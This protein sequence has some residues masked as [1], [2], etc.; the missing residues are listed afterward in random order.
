VAG[1]PLRV[2]IVAPPFYEIPPAGYGGTEA[3]CGSLV[4]GL[5]ARGHEVTLVAAG[6]DHTRARF[7]RTLPEAPGEGHEDE[8]N[9]ELLHAARA[10]SALD[11]CELD[12]V[13]DH[14]RTGPLTAAGRTIPTVATVHSAVAG[15]D[16]QVELWE[17]LGRHAPLI[18]L[19]DA[20]R[21][22]APHLNWHGR[23]YN[24]IPVERYPFREDKEDYVLFLGRMSPRKGVVPAIE[25]A[26]AA[27]RRIVIAGSWSVPAEQSYFEREVRAR[28][29]PDVEWAQ[30]V[31]GDAKKD[32]LARAA[33]LLFPVRWQEPFGLV[34]V[35][36]LACGTPVVA[37]RTGSVPE[38]VRDGETGIVCAGED[39]LAPAID[40]A[41]RLSPRHCRA[42]AE[43]RFSVERMARDYERCYR[44]LL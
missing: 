40:A 34:V 31:R 23:V 38:L 6:R 37:L 2:A 41:A 8:T 16:S 22:A 32:L 21:A 28:L 11:A 12:L 14:T 4:E 43:R 29:G 20:Q 1:R 35:E 13:H 30:E 5:I 42:D 25:A 27:G 18:A 44:T 15:P 3:V 7:V 10:A 33:C 17:A 19:S 26:R 24:G 36:A 39:E 9:I